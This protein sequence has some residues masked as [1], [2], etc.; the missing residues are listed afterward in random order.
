MSF[1]YKNRLCYERSTSKS[2]AWSLDEL[3]SEDE[4]SKM[5]KNYK[6][7]KTKKDICTKLEEKSK[8]KKKEIEIEIEEEWSDE[9]E[10][11]VKPKKKI[12]KEI[13]IEIE[14]D[15]FEKVRGLSKSEIEKSLKK[16]K[17]DELKVFLKSRGIKTTGKKDNLIQSI[18]VLL[19]KSGKDEE[20][21][22]DI[23]SCEKYK[24]IELKSQSKK[25]NLPISGS[26]SLLCDR[27]RKYYN[28]DKVDKKKIKDEV[29]VDKIEDNDYKNILFQK[30]KVYD[31][32]PLGYTRTNLVSLANE[33]GVKIKEGKKTLN[34][35]EICHRLK[36][37]YNDEWIDDKSIDN[38]EE[39][40]IE[41]KIKD[42]KC[43][44]ESTFVMMTDI[45][46]IPH[47]KYIKL[48]NGYCYD[49]EELIEAMILSNDENKNPSDS[50]NIT[51]IWKDDK[52][53]D[54]IIKHKGLDPEIKS[55]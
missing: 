2:G 36:T 35:K 16:Y 3:L 54:K 9:D 30:C 29:K 49:I 55:R 18:I 42:R 40:S 51:K 38:D 17:V 7:K 22:F 1:K 27:L 41:P 39:W 12:K 31:K 45:D 4:I 8:G 52:E 24:L 34:M 50:S 46:D 5:V 14:D 37:K 47:D 23:T 15:D 26:K 32:C 19:S 10:E 11:E 6:L 44:N 20:D 48:S 21:D 25:L 13:E 53:K 28:G 33:C 43:I